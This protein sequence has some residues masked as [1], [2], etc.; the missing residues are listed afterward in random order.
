MKVTVVGDVLLDVDING[1]STRLSPD[2]PVPVVDVRDIRRRAGGAG[3]V[4]TVLM[5]DGHDVALVTAVSDDEP[6]GHLRHIL[7]GVAVLSGAPLAPTPVKTRVRIGH[8][9]VVRYDE[10][11]AP[12]PIPGCTPEMVAAITGADAVVVADYGRGITANPDIRD[13]LAEAATRI[14]VVWDPHPAGSEP[15]P[16]VAVVTPNMSEAFAVAGIAAEDVS[17][18]VADRAGHRLKDKWGCKAVL[19][20]LAEDGAVL[21]RDPRPSEDAG[22]SEDPGPSKDGGGAGGA[23]VSIPAPSTRVDDPCGAGDRLAGSL[24]VYLASGL[25]LRAAATRAVEDASA[26]LADGGAATL[27]V[28]VPADAPADY[29]APTLTLAHFSPQFDEPD[30]AGASG[31]ASDRRD[32]NVP[33]TLPAPASGHAAGAA[34]DIAADGGPKGG[35]DGEPGGAGTDPIALARTIRAA[36]GT[37]VA[38]GGCFD[39][40]HAGHARTLAAARKLGDCLIVCLNTDA[41]VRRL[42]G[43]HRPIVSE[44]DRAELLLALECVDAVIL[45]DEDTP[46]A[47]LRRFRPDIWVKGGDYNADELPEARLMASWGGRCLTVPYHPARSTSGLAAALAKVG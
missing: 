36:G 15:V 2:A 14:P 19:V 28:T 3:L 33:G 42:K 25:E 9:A 20:T 5:R 4:A 40:L 45:F 43:P 47:C 23:A 37:V 6:A 10:G 31:P 38:T 12:A 24:A 26:F 22:P 18:S 32:H 34:A 21:I 11:C 7:D 8:H 30:S 39:L 35:L 41:S 16:G 46:E 1:R 13:A 27:A 44:D 29:G 17:L